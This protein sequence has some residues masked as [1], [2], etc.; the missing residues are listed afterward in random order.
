MLDEFTTLSLASSI[1]YEAVILCTCI[2][3]MTQMVLICEKIVHL[4]HLHLRQR[5]SSLRWVEKAV[6]PVRSLSHDTMIV[7]AALQSYQQPE[8]ICTSAFLRLLFSGIEKFTANNGCVSLTASTVNRKWD[9]IQLPNIWQGSFQRKRVFLSGIKSLNRY[10]AL[11]LHF[12]R[13]FCGILLLLRFCFAEITSDYAQTENEHNWKEHNHHLQ[14]TKPVAR[15]PKNLLFSM[16]CDE[17]WWKNYYFLHFLSFLFEKLRTLFGGGGVLVLFAMTSFFWA[18]SWTPGAKAQR[19]T[20]C[21]TDV[22]VAEKGRKTQVS[23]FFS[24]T[25]DFPTLW[26]AKDMMLK[27][28]KVTTDG[29]GARIHKGVWWLQETTT[30]HHHTASGGFVWNIFF[31]LKS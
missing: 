25:L 2:Y 24:Q 21:D 11:N 6:F 15:K 8:N 5:F 13:R 22:S 17:Y 28:Q 9:G 14:E 3:Q 27:E 12:P 1:N 20:W 31:S 30:S 23:I 7:L 19:I 18:L 16:L 10:R 26:A 4:R 29:I